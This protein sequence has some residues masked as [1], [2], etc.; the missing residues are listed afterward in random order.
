MRAIPSRLAW[1]CAAAL[2]LPACRG[3]DQAARRGAPTAAVS[4]SFTPSPTAAVAAPTP[5]GIS[6][7]PRAPSGTEPAAPSASLDPILRRVVLFSTDLPPGLSDGVARPLPSTGPSSLDAAADE[8]GRARGRGGTV[9]VTF[10]AAATQQADVI[11]IASGA[12]RFATNDG[13]RAQFQAIRDG[14]QAVI[15]DDRLVS[16]PRIGVPPPDGGR[17]DLAGVGDEALAWDRAGRSPLLAF[18]RGM[19]VVVLYAQ[20]Q[21]PD[22]LDTV[23]LARLLDQ[24]ASQ[25]QR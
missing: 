7:T 1:L 17:T 6:G 19:I 23:A 16:R 20:L 18:R 3:N 14:G 10:S 21:S 24:R 2:L 15:D 12:T 8:R 5:A 25:A 9:V 4:A 13:A 22:A 11:A